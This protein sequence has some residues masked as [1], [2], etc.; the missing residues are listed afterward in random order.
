VGIGLAAFSARQMNEKIA[1]NDSLADKQYPMV[2]LAAIAGCALIFLGLVLSAAFW[3][4]VLMR[5][6][7][8]LVAFAGPS[9]KV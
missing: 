4:P 7:G 2:L 1:G 3:L 6:V 8:A 5:V 9:A